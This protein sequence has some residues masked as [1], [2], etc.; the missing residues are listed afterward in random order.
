MDMSA[1]WWLR[2]C[3]ECY[4]CKGLRE[5]MSWPNLSLP[6]PNDLEIFASVEHFEPL[7]HHITAIRL[8]P[9]F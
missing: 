1:R 8:Q 5:M 4:P 9:Y 7:I 3:L 6:L 2:R